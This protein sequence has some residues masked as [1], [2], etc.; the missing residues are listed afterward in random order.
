MKPTAEAAN[1]GPTPSISG[2]KVKKI[3]ALASGSGSNFEAVVNACEKGILK[4]W[5]GRK[6]DGDWYWL[7]NE[8]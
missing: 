1:S 5:D 3:G 2:G 6:K 7:N 4:M 8:I